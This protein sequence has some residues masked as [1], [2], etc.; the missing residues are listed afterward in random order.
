MITEDWRV[1]RT[2]PKLLPWSGCGGYR[3][4]A[5]WRQPAAVPYLRY[6]YVSGGVATQD[7][8]LPETAARR[9]G[10]K[11]RS[12]LFELLCAGA[13][14]LRENHGH[15]NIHDLSVEDLCT[16]SREISEYTNIAHA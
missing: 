11:T 2:L 1:P 9:G 15:E 4:A 8:E 5:W 16:I 10:G 14:D 13:A 7:P 12:E 6:G 3:S